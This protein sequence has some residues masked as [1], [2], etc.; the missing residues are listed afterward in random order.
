MNIIYNSHLKLIIYTLI[1]ISITKC[2]PMD[3]SNH[4]KKNSITFI[5]STWFTQG[6]RES[7]EDRH[8]PYDDEN[9]IIAEN[10]AFFG[11]YDGHAG[12]YSADFVSKQLHNSIIERP[13]FIFG[14]IEQAIKEGYEFLDERCIAQGFDDG[15][16]AVTA[17]IKGS[18]LW[19]SNVGDSEAIG[20]DGESVHCLTK[21]HKPTDP[22]EMQRI[23]QH[24]NSI[25]TTF[26]H[27]T[28][29][30]EC[31]VYKIKTIKTII[32]QNSNSRE[33]HGGKKTL[34]QG[35]FLKSYSAFDG[36]SV[37]EYQSPQRSFIESAIGRLA[38]SRSIGDASFKPVNIATPFI[39]S[40]VVEKPIFIILATDG[41]WDTMSYDSAAYIVIE[42]L[43]QHNLN[44]SNF[45]AQEIRPLAQEVAIT[46][47]KKLVEMA[48]ELEPQTDN[49]T[50]SIIFIAPE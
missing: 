38:M 31:G 44:L 25:I 50:V 10:T 19:I 26:D 9:P 46:A 28:I 12:S 34:P 14:D 32:K 2:N 4:Q 49:T 33:I 15:T 47:A 48:Q 5:Q 37:A 43:L 40:F 1:T 13:S 36:K 27:A 18:T 24:E 45:F 8:F 17:L 29:Q 7:M 39:Q 30:N 41:L 22:E 35:I 3:N 23:L 6:A 21:K 11:I 16:T 20:F 42:H